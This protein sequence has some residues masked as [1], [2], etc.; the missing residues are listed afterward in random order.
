MHEIFT[1]QLTSIII[2]FFKT[3][4]SNEHNTK[5]YNNFAG[6]FDIKVS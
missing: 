1:H 5:V 6:S 3:E 4:I 2:S